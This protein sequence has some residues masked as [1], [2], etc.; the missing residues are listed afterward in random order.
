MA[1]RFAKYISQTPY[2]V[3]IAHACLDGLLYDWSNHLEHAV[4]SL[5][6]I[7]MNMNQSN[8]VLSYAPFK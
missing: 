4:M 1:R 5:Y 8:P 3:N 2:R 6:T 7:V